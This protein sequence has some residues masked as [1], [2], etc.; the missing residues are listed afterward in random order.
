MSYN[1]ILIVEDDPYQRR[2]MARLLRS[3]GHHVLVADSG[4]EALRVLEAEQVS[5]VL[6]DRKMPL[7]DGLQLAKHVRTFYPGI[8]VAVITAYPDGMDENGVD[9]VLNKPYSGQQL[10]DLVQSLVEKSGV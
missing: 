6:T 9:A 5:V 2:Q 7:M 8:I 1:S 10:R 4:L 3:D